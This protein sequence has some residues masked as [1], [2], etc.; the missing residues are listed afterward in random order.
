VSVIGMTALP[1]AKL[2]REAEL[3]YAT[4]AFV[5][6]YDCWH[7]TEAP[8]SVQ[9]VIAVLQKNS[10]LAKRLVLQLA[11]DLPDPAQSSA[12]CALEHAVISAKDSISSEARARLGWLLDKYLGARA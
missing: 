12:S 3:P 7:E 4:V 1:E 11:G 2:A 9:A 8:V 10:A 5:T 6:D